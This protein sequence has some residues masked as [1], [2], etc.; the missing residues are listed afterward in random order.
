MLEQAVAHLLRVWVLKQHAG[1]PD[2]PVLAK[3][4]RVACLQAELPKKS[5]V[6]H[7]V[8]CW[9]TAAWDVQPSLFITQ[10]W[11]VSTTLELLQQ[12]CHPE[13]MQH[14]LLDCT[15]SH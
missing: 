11:R 9:E 7:Q 12:A 2:E 6:L 13:V 1:N 15:G 14:L 5:R 10:L 4:Q 3:L 8:G